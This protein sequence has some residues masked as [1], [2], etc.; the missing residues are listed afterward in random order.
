VCGG[1]PTCRS[2]LGAAALARAAAIAGLRLALL[3]APGAE[4]RPMS[5][6]AVRDMGNR[7]FPAHLD[8]RYSE[9]AWC[10]G[11]ERYSRPEPWYTF[12]RARDIRDRYRRLDG[13][14]DDHQLPQ[15]GDAPARRRAARNRAIARRRAEELERRR[16]AGLEPPRPEWVWDCACRC[17]PC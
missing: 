14:P 4:V 8:T 2:A 10:H 1:R 15:P 3:D 9:E 12:D 11:R 13:V 6:D 5:D 7:R 16:A 17:D